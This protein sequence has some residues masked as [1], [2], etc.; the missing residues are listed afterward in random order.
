[1]LDA[2][3]VRLPSYSRDR[4]KVRDCSAKVRRVLNKH[5]FNTST[6]FYTRLTAVTFVKGVYSEKCCKAR[7]YNTKRRKCCSQSRD[8][9]K[10]HH[11]VKMCTGHLRGGAHDVDGGETQARARFT[12]RTRGG[13]SRSRG[14]VQK[15]RE[16]ACGFGGEKR[17]EGG[18]RGGGAV[19]GRPTAAC[20]VGWRESEPCLAAAE[21]ESF[22]PEAERPPPS[23]PRLR[24]RRNSRRIARWQRRGGVTGGGGGM[25]V[26]QA[27]T[28]LTRDLKDDV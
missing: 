21:A 4:L 15:S 5:V 1:M 17:Q 16:A 27:G 10:K 3:C 13:V 14:A 2:L 26:A 11:C 20:T 12:G 24:R 22:V 25:V 7:K 18:G 23:P 28:R 8:Q 19:A 9:K 6:R